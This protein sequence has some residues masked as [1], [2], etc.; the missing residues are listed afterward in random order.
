VPHAVAAED[1]H[2]R[3]EQVDQ[4]DDA[5]AEPVADPAD[6]GPGGPVT[7]R[8]RGQHV[9]ERRA[10]RGA[11]RL[12]PPVLADLGLPAAAAPAPAPPALGVDRHVADLAGVPPGALQRAPAEDDAA[13][14]HRAG[15]VDHVGDPGR[16]APQVLGERT[17]VGV[18]ADRDRPVDPELGG[19]QLRQRHV[20]PADVRR[21]ADQAVPGPHHRAHRR[22]DAEADGVRR[23]PVQQRP[24]QPGQP[25][26]GP[27]HVVVAAG[28]AARPR[29][30]HDAAEPDPGGDQPL[31]ARCRAPA[32]TRAR[33]AA[34]PGSTAG[35][36]RRCP[37]APTPAQVG[38]GQVGRQ[39][40]HR[41]AVQAGLAVSAERDAAPVTCSRRST[42]PR[43]WRRTSPWVATAGLV[44]CGLGKTP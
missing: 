12:E 18:V 27:V 14:A 39:G 21:E 37:P 19:E 33:T 40:P 11:G 10:G 22:A 24:D 2:L 26:Q 15:Q 16:R 17:E 42:L 4:V 31:D 1:D 20:H 35:P 29:V 5:D 23:R 8:V 36:P 28:H 30:Q 13:D 32:R 6:A 34:R 9:D 44:T 3:V 43:L 25:A 38:I 7:G 41:A